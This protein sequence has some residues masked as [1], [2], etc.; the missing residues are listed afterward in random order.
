MDQGPV[1][2]PVVEKVSGKTIYVRMQ[3]GTLP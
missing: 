3:R 1:E 2:W